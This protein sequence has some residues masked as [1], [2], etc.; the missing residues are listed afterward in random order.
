MCVLLGGKCRGGQT[1][2]TFGAAFAPSSP[3]NGMLTSSDFLSYEIH[4]TLATNPF[5]PI[6]LARIAAGHPG[7]GSSPPF[8]ASRNLFRSR[9]V[10]SRSNNRYFM[11][12]RN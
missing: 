1:R 3:R 5:R 11:S 6:S 8:N 4:V 9:R 2:P 10:A 7:Q 12:K